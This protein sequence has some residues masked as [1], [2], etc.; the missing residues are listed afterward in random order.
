L[1]VSTRLGGGAYSQ[2]AVRDHYFRIAK[3]SIPD[4]QYW[5][6]LYTGAQDL[7]GALADEGT[8][9]SDEESEEANDENNS[10][11]D[12]EGAND[13]DMDEDTSESSGPADDRDDDSDDDDDSSDNAPLGDDLPLRPPPARNPN[14]VPVN[15]FVGA[16]G[17]PPAGGPPRNPNSA[18]DSDSSSEDNAPLVPSTPQRNKKRKRRYLGDSDD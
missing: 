4:C 16:G 10:A 2:H 1:Q 14:E 15:R 11:S 9:A 3:K 17:P 7:S 13:V 8:R 18:R 12:G 6:E 5:A